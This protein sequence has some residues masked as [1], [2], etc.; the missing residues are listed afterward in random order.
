MRERASLAVRTWRSIEVELLGAAPRAG[1]SL[2]EE[3]WRPD[4][5]TAYCHRCGGSVGVGEAA[6]S[7]C[8]A[9]R[10]LSLPWSSAVRLGRYEGGLKDAVRS[11]KFHS[12]RHAGRVLGRALGS[13]IRVTLERRGDPRAILVPVPT[14]EYRRLW[15]NRGVDHTLQL[16]RHASAASGVP[17]ARLLSRRHRPPQSETPPSKRV[18]NVR[19]AFFLRSGAVV[20]SGVTVVLIDDVRTS[21]ATLRACYRAISMETGRRREMASRIV[22]ATVAVAGERRRGDSTTVAEQEIAD[23]D[24]FSYPAA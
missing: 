16:L 7:G 21:G 24:E 8:S 10:E 1:R 2:I 3:N 22:V 9:C 23:Q 12:D 18:E 5:A 11:L 17:I 14:T 15:R 19:R 4:A 6:A 13:R 20:P